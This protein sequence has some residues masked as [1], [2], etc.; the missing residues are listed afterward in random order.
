M[1]NYRIEELR[2]TYYKKLNELENAK[3][4]NNKLEENIIKQS[5]IN[6]NLIKARG[7]LTILQNIEEEARINGNRYKQNRVSRIELEI[8]SSIDY[9]FPDENLSSKIIVDEKG[10]GKAKLVLLD[11]RNKARNPRN[12]EGGLL[13]QLVSFTASHGISRMQGVNVLFVDEAF[14]N[15]SP[16]NKAKVGTILNK[17][18]EEGMQI[19]LITQGGELYQDLSRKMIYLTKELGNVCVEKTE[20]WRS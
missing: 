14:G 20:E 3:T 17:C 11:E 4:N 12:T 5:Q 10:K 16:E 7:Y 8:D 18:V 6:D 2:K 1:N 19:I 15:S 9:I 13:K